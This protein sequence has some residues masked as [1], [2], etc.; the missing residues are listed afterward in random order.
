MTR[1][2]M[3]SV[4]RSCNYNRTQCTNL[5]GSVGVECKNNDVRAH[6]CRTPSDV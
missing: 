3:T 6:G 2:G 4:R 5:Y 1:G